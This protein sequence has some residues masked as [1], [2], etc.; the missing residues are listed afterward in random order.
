M[1][2]SAAFFRVSSGFFAIPKRAARGILAGAGA[3][4]LSATAS[5]A[6]RPAAASIAPLHSLLQ[7]VM[8]KTGEARLLISPAETPHG[9]Q[10]APSRAK[11]LHNAAAVF[12]LGESFET[13]LRPALQALPP[14]VRRV[15]LTDEAALLPYRGHAHGRE[16]YD[17]HIWLDPV[18][19][20]QIARRIAREL[21]AANPARRAEYETNARRL[22]ARLKDLDLRLAKILAAARGR[23][24][25]AMHEGY[26]Y[27]ARRYGLAEAV[28]VSGGAGRVSARRLQTAR[29]AIREKNIRCLFAETHAP[30]QKTVQFAKSS[31]AP[32]KIIIIDPL[33]AAFPPGKNLYFQ[34]MENMA[35]AFAGCLSAP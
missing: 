28:S 7:S 19:A 27:F 13:F 18:R 32:I 8:G 3:A 31:G 12:Y 33:G 35:R 25:A 16:I 11:M 10:L 5:A 15:R 2:I 22:E 14:D 24:Y 4:I 29:R 6:E 1:K 30:P 17:M 34:V 9:A 20:Q 26:Q 21:A 23:P